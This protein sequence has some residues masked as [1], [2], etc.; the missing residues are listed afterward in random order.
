VHDP[1]FVTVVFQRPRQMNRKSDFVLD[2][3]DSHDFKFTIA[4]DGARGRRDDAA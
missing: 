4:L 3:Q 2:H 1:N